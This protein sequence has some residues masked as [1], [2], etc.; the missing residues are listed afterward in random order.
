VSLAPWKA[1]AFFEKNDG[2]LGWSEVWYPMGS[3]IDAAAAT[4][5]G[6]WTIRKTLLPTQYSLAYMRVGMQSTKRYTVIPS[7]PYP[8]PGTYAGGTGAV[9]VPSEAAVLVL[10]EAT[11][12]LKN[13]KFFHGLWTT[14]VTNGDTFTP[15]SDWLTQWAL[16]QTEVT[17]NFYAQGDPADPLSEFLAVTAVSYIRL[18]KHNIGRPFDLYRGRRRPLTSP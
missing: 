17:S 2:A 5:Q 9:L 14:D 7:E 16:F 15:S 3:D 10:L 6:W 11:P 13:R 12:G 1:V 4:M 18:T 8:D